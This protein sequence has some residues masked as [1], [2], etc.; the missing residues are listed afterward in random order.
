M[1][2]L[3]GCTLEFIYCLA[4]HVV[5]FVTRTWSVLVVIS[6]EQMSRQVARSKGSTRLMQ[7]G[8]RSVDSLCNETFLHSRHHGVRLDGCYLLFVELLLAQGLL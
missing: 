7:G 3:F 2:Q 4:H 8:T 1:A 5:H 6:L